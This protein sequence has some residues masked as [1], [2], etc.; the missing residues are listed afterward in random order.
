ML[1]FDEEFAKIRGMNQVRLSLGQK[2][3]RKPLLNFKGRMQANKNP[4][5]RDKDDQDLEVLSYSSHHSF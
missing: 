3:Y 1:P 5:G 2:I 4:Y